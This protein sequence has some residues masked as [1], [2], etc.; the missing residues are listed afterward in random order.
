MQVMLANNTK[1]I[2]H[3][4]AGRFPGSVGHLY[5]PGAQRGPYEYLPYALD[6]GAYGAFTSGKEWDE[7]AWVDL[8]E[9][10]KLSGQPPK[11][12]LVPDVVG[13]RI[14][15]LRRWD[16][17]APVAAQYG[18]P[19]AFAVQDGM[20]LED[21]PAD[22]QVVF[23]GGSTDWKWSTV[24]LWAAFPRCHVGRVN[25]YRRLVQCAA[26]GVESVDGT[27]WMREPN[28]RQFRGLVA[29]IEEQFGVRVRHVQEALWFAQL[30]WKN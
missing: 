24:E 3:W 1:G 16:M 23:V 4:L 7:S 15:T 17:Y 11:W 26:L 30:C 27:G 18:W 29:F 22:A 5:S 20:T 10:A 12:V 19:L 25:E 13:D 9:W 21:I 28:G 8:L 14:R 2:V 6:N